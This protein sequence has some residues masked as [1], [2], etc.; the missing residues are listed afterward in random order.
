MWNKECSIHFE[1]GKMVLAGT[2]RAFIF[3]FR[4]SNFQN[5][6]YLRTKR[7]NVAA[8]NPHNFKKKK[9]RSINLTIRRETKHQ[10]SI[11]RQRFRHSRWIVLNLRNRIIEAALRNLSYYYASYFQIS[12]LALPSFG[13]TISTKRLYVATFQDLTTIR[14]IGKCAKWCQWSWQIK[15][16]QMNSW[17]ESFLLYFKITKF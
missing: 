5:Q 10:R 6:Q 16:C 11:D 9:N 12:I 8:L 13:K 17:T 14:P 15:L 3:K 4:I 1:F 7:M 2:K